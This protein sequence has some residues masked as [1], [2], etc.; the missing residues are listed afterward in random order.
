MSIST[1][2]LFGQRVVLSNSACVYWPGAIDA[3]YQYQYP[4][5][6]GPEVYNTIRLE[7]MR[8]AGFMDV[9]MISDG[10]MEQCHRDPTL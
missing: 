6:S 7:S 8:Q 10:D 9:R 2:S 5:M 1:V 3:I 4:P